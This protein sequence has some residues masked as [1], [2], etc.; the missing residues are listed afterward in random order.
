MRGIDVGTI[1]AEHAISIGRASAVQPAATRMVAAR[2]SVRSDGKRRA[3]RPEFQGLTQSISTLV[4]A[5][6]SLSH[7]A[8]QQ[9]GG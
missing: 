7:Q 5:T 2:I 6:S 8:L 3:L 1:D 9:V 4:A